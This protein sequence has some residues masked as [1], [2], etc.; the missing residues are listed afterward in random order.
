MRTR[1]VGKED[2][3]VSAAVR[4][5]GY[6]IQERFQAKWRHIPDASTVPL[7]DLGS[8]IVIWDSV[9]L[10]KEPDGTISSCG[11]LPLPP[12]DMEPYIPDWHLS[13]SISSQLMLYRLV[14]TFGGLEWQ[15][16]DDYQ[17][18]WAYDLEFT[19]DELLGI[20]SIFD[21]KGSLCVRF[22]GVKEA[23][24]SALELLTWL[25]STNVPH[26]YDGTV[27]GTKA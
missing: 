6:D 18:V 7:H 26:S 2:H 16:R 5:N 20:L 22:D 21:Y 23:S 3:D 24:E 13:G 10:V 11:P 12:H 14:I 4:G 15:I 1:K 19:E 27:A 8:D 25:M 9:H 17:S